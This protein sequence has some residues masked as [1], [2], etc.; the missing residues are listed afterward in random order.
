MISPSPATPEIEYASIAQVAERILGKDEVSS[1]NLLRSSTGA[2]N[3]RKRYGLRG[4]VV[5]I[6][7]LGTAMRRPGKWNSIYLQAEVFEEV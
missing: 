6:H 4:F 7:F 5:P 2:R 1:S 3:P